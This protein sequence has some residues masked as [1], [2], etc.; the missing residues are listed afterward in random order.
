MSLNI[1]KTSDN[2]EIANFVATSI[3]KKLKENNKVFWLVCGG[4]SIPLEILISKKINFDT[5]NNL[6][7]SLTDERFGSVGHKDSNLEKL[8]DGGFQIHNAKLVPFLIGKD[9]R[10]TTEEVGVSL[11][12]EFIKADYKIGVFGIGIDGHIAG[13]LPH[14]VAVNNKDI[15]CTYETDIF[16]RV[17]ITPNTINKLNE[18]VVY[19]MGENK[20]PVLEL[21]EKE[22]LI[23]DCPAQ[24]LK[25]VPLVTIFTDY[26]VE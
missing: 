4:S 15:I 21:L 19:A 22:L 5:S 14:T 11:S 25:K 8:L 1:I 23:D 9:M 10:L 17:T 7:I 24:I 12:H 16:N 3:N 18:A 6:V 20:W 13:I 2:E 26:K